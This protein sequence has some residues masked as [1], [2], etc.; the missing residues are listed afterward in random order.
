[1]ADFLVLSFFF[2]HPNY[3]GKEN[4]DVGSQTK[5]KSYFFFKTNLELS[6]SNQCIVLLPFSVYRKQV[7]ILHMTQIHLPSSN[8]TE[9][10]ESPYSQ[11]E[12]GW[13]KTDLLL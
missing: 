6:L 9:N 8:S 7:Q 10:N 4:Q 1:M 2:S 11:K 3:T 5:V 13:Q 12:T